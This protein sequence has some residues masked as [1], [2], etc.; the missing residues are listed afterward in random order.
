MG[1]RHRIKKYGLISQRRISQF[2]AERLLEERGIVVNST[3]VNCL[4]SYSKRES[5]KHFI[6]KA[7]IFKILRNKGRKV[8]CEVEINNGIVDLLDLDNLIAYE[9]ESN[10]AKGKIENKLRNYRAVE[11]VIFIDLREVPNDLGKAEKFLK[12][13]VVL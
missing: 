9:I 11:D 7:M 13:I 1:C 6:V 3:N 5:L 2:E 10:L 12:K 4:F 8:A